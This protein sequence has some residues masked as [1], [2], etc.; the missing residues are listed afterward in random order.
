MK[1]RRHRSQLCLQQSFDTIAEEEED[2]YKP[3]EQHFEKLETI[4]GSFN[5]SVDSTAHNVICKPATQITSEKYD[6]VEEEEGEGRSMPSIRPFSSTQDSMDTDISE[7]TVNSHIS[8]SSTA[9]LKR[10]SCEELPLNDGSSEDFHDSLQENWI[11]ND[12]V[13]TKTEN[14]SSNYVTSLSEESLNWEELKSRVEEAERKAFTAV[15]SH[16]DRRRKFHRL[17]QSISLPVAESEK[18][19]PLRRCI[20]LYVEETETETSESD[21][22]LSTLAGFKLTDRKINTDDSTFDEVTS[23]AADEPKDPS[24][25][26]KSPKSPLTLP[27]LVIGRLSFSPY[28]RKLL[29]SYKNSFITHFYAS[30]DIVE[31]K[32]NIHCI[33]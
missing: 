20:T 29:R 16:Q 21:F 18:I 15:L 12:V 17:R 32:K 22:S 2:H 26:P 9:I 7:A 11:A 10:Q 27:K 6:K 8:K 3:S 4:K 28:S 5:I 33:I 19:Y 24:L 14:D 23:A 13:V 25:S 1:L 30:S 31:T